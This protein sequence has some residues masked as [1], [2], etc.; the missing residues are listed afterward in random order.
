[1]K[2]GTVLVFVKLN[3]EFNMQ[4]PLAHL[5]HPRVRACVKS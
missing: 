4:A 1:M 5:T 3:N 2:R